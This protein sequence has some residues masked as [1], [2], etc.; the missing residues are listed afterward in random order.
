M[1][2]KLAFAGAIMMVSSLAAADGPAPVSFA[3]TLE[4]IDASQA[5]SMAK[6][7]ASTTRR[8]GKHVY[9]AVDHQPEA[10]S[11]LSGKTS[12]G[13]SKLNDNNAADKNAKA[14][15]VSSKSNVKHG[16]SATR[17][18][19][20]GVRVGKKASRNAETELAGD[21]LKDAKA[22]RKG[23]KN[24]SSKGAQAGTQGG[25]GQKQGKRAH[26]RPDSLGKGKVRGQQG[27]R[28][29]NWGAGQGR[30]SGHG[31]GQQWKGQKG[32]KGFGG[33][34]GVGQ[35]GGG[36]GSGSGSG[37]GKQRGPR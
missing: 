15:S 22:L 18:K 5:E 34:S 9:I 29:E 31:S 14:C 8:E 30:G 7:I 6:K 4:V 17:L 2:S 36:S 35:G 11:S 3:T 27:K 33:G 19:P 13:T 21:L 32:P 24:G 1:G 28:G 10:K 12:P 25:K 20:R 23:K 37:A 26:A 16:R